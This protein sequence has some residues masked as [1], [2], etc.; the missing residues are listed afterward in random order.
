MA[1]LPRHDSCHIGWRYHERRL[2][3]MTMMPGSHA[4]APITRRR[5]LLAAIAI[6]VLLL[7]PLPARAA[8]TINFDSG[9]DGNAIGEDFAALGVHFGAAYHYYNDNGPQG[10]LGAYP[11]SSGANSAYGPAG[12]GTTITFDSP[13]TSF[14]FYFNNGIGPAKF[15]AW[16]EGLDTG[17]CSLCDQVLAVNVPNGPTLK[18][19]SAG[20]GIIAIRFFDGDLTLDDF[21]F[22]GASAPEP[23]S[24][25]LLGAG[26]VALA[27]IARARR[28][29]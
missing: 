29:R 17:I 15:N 14:S 22:E 1:F 8:T 23:A 18:S 21:T 5:R 10:T 6:G 28:R 7:L 13:V 26:F 27:G 24:L 12:D 2:A 25:V 4:V 19:Y 11:A 3:E 9:T 20:P 16:S